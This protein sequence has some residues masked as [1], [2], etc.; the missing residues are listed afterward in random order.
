MVRSHSLPK[1]ETHRIQSENSRIQNVYIDA[2]K[3]LLLNEM[4]INTQKRLLNLYIEIGERLP[5]IIIV[6]DLICKLDYLLSQIYFSKGIKVDFCV[7]SSELFLEFTK[8]SGWI[9]SNDPF[10]GIV[11]LQGW[12]DIG[13]G[14]LSVYTADLPNVINIVLGKKTSP[15]DVGVH[16]L[17]WDR[18]YRK[19]IKSIY[20]VKI[21]SSTFRVHNDLKSFSSFSNKIQLLSIE[22]IQLFGE[23]N[24]W[25]G[26]I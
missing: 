10:T 5:D 6:K 16:F 26:K 4:L 20:E 2:L 22:K 18:F 7:V 3:S 14:R 9:R 23:S 15:H 17:E 12:L 24:Y 21:K 8:Q 11:Q 1:A 13:F 19:P 25:C